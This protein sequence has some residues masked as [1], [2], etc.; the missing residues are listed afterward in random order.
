MTFQDFVVA[1]QAA[2]SGD[3]F[4]V[5]PETFSVMVHFTSMEEYGSISAT[6]YFRMCD[7][8]RFSYQLQ[9]ED[10]SHEEEFYDTIEELLS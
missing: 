3:T 7:D 4:T 9:T 5:E 6:R 10:Y 1:V 2:F 8:G